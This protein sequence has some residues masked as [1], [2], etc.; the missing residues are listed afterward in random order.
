MT[1]PDNSERHQQHYK[2]NNVRTT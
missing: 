2:T 1:S